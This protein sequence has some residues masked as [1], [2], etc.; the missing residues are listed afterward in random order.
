[1]KLKKSNCKQQYFRR[2]ETG[3]LSQ[4]ESVD[5]INSQIKQTRQ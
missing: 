1:M 2:F 5:S 4:L 3:L